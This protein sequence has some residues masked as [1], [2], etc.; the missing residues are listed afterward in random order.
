MS[1]GEGNV[2]FYVRGGGPDQNLVLLY[3]AVV[4][5][6]GHLFGFFSVFNADAIKNTT[7][8]KGGMP[9]EE[10]FFNFS[11]IYNDYDFEFSGCQDEWSINVFSGV[12]DLNLKLDFDY[13]PRPQHQIE[14]GINYTYHKLTPNIAS[15]TDGETVLNN[16]RKAQFAHEAALYWQDDFKVSDRLSVNAGVRWSAFTQL[17]PYTSAENNRVFS[18]GEPVKKDTGLG[19]RITA[20]YSLNES[21]SLKAGIT[22]S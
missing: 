1:A 2:G 22:K 17:G 11:A 4:Y 8:I 16:E 3:E 10:L 6:S 14:F 21:S 20:K 15:A 13:S 5:N 12:R 9:S 18:Q 19:P 7:L